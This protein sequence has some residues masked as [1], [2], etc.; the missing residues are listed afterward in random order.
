L[1]ILIV[2]IVA[3]NFLEFE[4]KILDFFKNYIKNDVLDI[5]VP[6]ITSLGNGGFIWI[7]LTVILLLIKKTRKT[8]FY[9]ALS[10]ILS[11]V[12]CNL[13]LK[14]IIARPRPFEIY[15]D[16]TLLIKAPTD[17]SFPSGHSASSFAA[18]FAFLMGNI[19]I[20]DDKKYLSNKK[21]VFALLFLA[22]LIAL[23][24]LYLYVHF[25][26]DVFVAILLG[27]AFGYIS[28]KIVDFI[29]A[30]NRKEI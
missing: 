24:R 17:F 5:I 3:L 4:Y 29:Y 9:M 23:S 12:V 15:K 1:P 2:P 27:I 16:M 13:T 26:S 25:P 20:K 7:L 8:G 28:A 30:K 6:F 19:K 10:L 14:P 21:W 11:F 18:A 22:T